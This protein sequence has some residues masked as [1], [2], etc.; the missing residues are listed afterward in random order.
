[1]KCAFGIHAD[2]HNIVF[3][4]M[5]N[6]IIMYISSDGGVTKTTNA[7]LTRYAAINNGY[8]TTQ[9]YNVAG[10]ADGK[11]IIGGT[12]DNNTLLIE[13]IEGTTKSTLSS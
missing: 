4:T 2:K 8:S 11:I 7:S 6:P 12:Q 9:F 5:A 10:S 1:M 13:D 3:D